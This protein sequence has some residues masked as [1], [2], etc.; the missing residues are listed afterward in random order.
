M[1]ISFETIQYLLITIN[2][3]LTAGIA[4]TAFALLL[5]TSQFNLRN[6]VAGTF[7]LILLCVVIIY[8][9]ESI[10]S[11]IDNQPAESLLIRLEWVGIIILPATYLQFSDAILATTGKPSRWKRVWAIRATYLACIVFLTALPFPVIF[12]EISFSQP[13]APHMEPTL[14][15]VAFSLFYIVVMAMSWFN[16]FRAYRRTTTSASR[17]R[18]AYL[19]TG[20][21]APAFGSFPFLLFGSGIASQFT[22]F[23][24]MIALFSN[25]LVA[26]LM[27]LMAYAVAFFGVTWP[28]RV[29]KSRLLEWLMRGPLTAILAL[30]V[31]T[32]IRRA[33]AAYGNAYT[34]YV[35]ISLV[36]IILFVQ[37]AISF[38]FPF[39]ERW[40]FFG[41]DR[42]DLAR[43]RNF[44]NH[45]LT[46]NDLYQFMDLVISAICDRLQ[47][48]GGFIA[49]P[50]DSRAEV[51]TSLGNN[52]RRQDE[53]STELS[54]IVSENTHSEEYVTWGDDL[55]IPIWGNES[56]GE[57]LLGLIGVT[58]EGNQEFEKD[59][60]DDLKVLIDRARLALRDRQMQIQVFDAFQNLQPE[61]EIIQRM[62]AAG[63]YDEQFLFET[64][65]NLAQNDTVQWV[66]D[67][68]T[69]Y[70]GGPRLTQNPLL[71]L[72]IVTDALPKYE[73][74]GTNALRSILR[75]AIDHIKPEGERRYTADW[76]L[77]NILEM[78]FIEGRKVRDIALRL[79]VSEADLYRKQKIAI[80][81]VAGEISKMEK[82]AKENH[83]I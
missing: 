50:A 30:G 77:F 49:I 2:Q 10:S 41:K 65:V 12:G 78:K 8:S 11:S 70:W 27:V 58:G 18:M 79:S 1:T 73:G 5:S 4:I 74:S 80:E 19:I 25:F 3:I 34:A 37:F 29:V 68:L 72:K 52:H 14:V 44:E 7:A 57:S 59:Q 42:E 23:F 64:G 75:E 16:F 40:L 56:D 61:V 32:V 60:V 48:Q 45:F 28:D 36:L 21:L 82:H 31:T 71:K 33:G 53:V 67:A 22:F 9:A 15:T 13:F 38:L 51:I 55:L 39:L 81:T 62:R 24:W 26:G 35:P 66:R 63:R 17:R 69:H 47:A 83:Q 76:I 54:R 20:A 43:L 46:P 6:R